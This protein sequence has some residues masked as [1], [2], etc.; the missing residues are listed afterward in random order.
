MCLGWLD[1]NW[2]DTGYRA[3]Y[4]KL[5]GEYS[6]Y[7][8]V[9]EDCFHLNGYSEVMW[10]EG[11]GEYKRMN[12][13][14]PRYD[15]AISLKPLTG[16]DSEVSADR[17][18]YYWKRRNGTRMTVEF[19]PAWYGREPEWRDD[20][21]GNDNDPEAQCTTVTSGQLRSQDCGDL[22]DVLG[23]CK[24]Q[25]KCPRAS[26]C[27]EIG[28]VPTDCEVKGGSCLNGGRCVDGKNTT[29]GIFQCECAEGFEGQRCEI[30]VGGGVPT[31]CGNGVLDFGEECDTKGGDGCTDVCR[32]EEGYE[33]QNADSG[34][35]EEPCEGE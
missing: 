29:D 24:V 3:R 18:N 4:F 28:A 34:L 23:I 32:I 15:Y 1:D 26:V 12:A 5:A 13:T 27:R 20:N 11:Q 33:C 25:V 30:A 31:T 35:T 22:E 16:S 2:F 14:Y 8:E 6:R 10:F 7:V 21:D 17:S 19:L 9:E